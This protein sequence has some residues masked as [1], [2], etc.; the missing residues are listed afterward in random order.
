M[1]THPE[2]ELP[3]FVRRNYV[4][5]MFEAVIRMRTLEGCSVGETRKKLEYLV[6]IMEGMFWAVAAGR[7]VDLDMH[8]AFHKFVVKFLNFCSNKNN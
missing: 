1:L 2:V 7:N 4:F 8:V 3:T 5:D 6:K